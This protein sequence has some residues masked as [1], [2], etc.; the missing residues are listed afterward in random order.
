MLEVNHTPS[1]NSDTEVDAEVKNHLVRNT[2]EIIQL[3]VE[4]RRRVAFE[5]KQEMREAQKNNN[6]TRM[7]VKEHTERV[8]FDP[9]LVE[10]K[11]K[12][13]KFKLI[14]PKDPYDETDIYDKILKKATEMWKTSTG[15]NT[16]ERKV[17][18]S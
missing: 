10:K 18:F 12:G 1:F 5:M 17:P 4:Q 3:S 16:K 13:N 2:L 6:Y 7:S 8:R 15:T 14:Y 11:L 9:R